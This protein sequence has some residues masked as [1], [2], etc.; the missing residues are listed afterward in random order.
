VDKGQS[1][2]TGGER[3]AASNALFLLLTNASRIVFNAGLFLIIARILGAEELGRYQFALSYAALFAVVVHLGLN[4]LIIRQVAVNRERGPFYFTVGIIVKSVMGVLITAVTVITISLSGKSSS[5]QEM[6]FAAALTTTLITGIETVVVAFFYAH[7]RMSYVLGLS[8]LKSA[9]N[10]AVG[11]AVALS[12]WGAR[13]ILWGFLG[14]EVVCAVLVFIW[15]RGRL[16]VWFTSV[17]WRDFPTTLWHSLPF[18]LNGVFITV[19]TQLHYSLLSFYAGDKAT[20]IYTAA[21]KLITFLNFIPS[22]LTQALYPYLARLAAGQGENPRGPMM[23]WVRY[24]AAISFPAA[25]LLAFRAAPFID[26][27]Y[28]RGY[29]ASARVLAVLGFALPFSFATYPYAIALNAIHRERANTAVA[30]GAAL[31]NVA[32]NFILIPRLGPLGAAIS[33][34]ITEAA[35]SIA[36]QILVRLWMGSLGLPSLLVRLAVPAVLMALLMQLTDRLPLYAE[37]PLLVIVYLGTAFAVG[38]IKRDDLG[39]WLRRPAAPH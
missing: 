34:L 2:Q 30:A 37:L 21:A 12:G 38:A 13:G 29:G 26:L 15:A 10:A 6:V 8:A 3:K 11:I 25:V 20:G 14:V 4:D 9:L 32:A 1:P 27:V 16:G 28:G 35:Q 19:Y 39:T 18:A 23:R 5:V 7:E 31:I 17:R 36:R 24:L 22:A 33:F